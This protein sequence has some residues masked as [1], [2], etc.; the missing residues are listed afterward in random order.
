M[1]TNNQTASGAPEK[2]RSVAQEAGNSEPL[3]PAH[4]SKVPQV[5]KRYVTEEK[6]EIK[7]SQSSSLTD[8]QSSHSVTEPSQPEAD[9]EPMLPRVQLLPASVA[10][11]RSAPVNDEDSN[12]PEGSQ[13]PSTRY[14]SKR[15]KLTKGER[16]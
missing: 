13:S 16:S 6:T 1:R 2:T 8:S 10:Q 5:A 15:A 3:H 9:P 12:L 11:K 7:D 14:A 4:D